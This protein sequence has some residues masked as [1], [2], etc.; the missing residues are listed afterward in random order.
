MNSI[1]VVIVLVDIGKTV[2]MFNR[3]LFASRAHEDR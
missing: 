1:L 3:D 2:V